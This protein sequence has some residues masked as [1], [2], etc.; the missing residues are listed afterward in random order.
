MGLQSVPPW[1][2]RW[3]TQLLEGL[4]K[5]PQGMERSGTPCGDETTGPSQYDVIAKTHRWEVPYAAVYFVGTG[6]DRPESERPLPSG[7][8]LEEVGMDPAAVV[9]PKAAQSGPL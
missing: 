8:C 7:P 4:N 9:R 6:Y 3:H 1:E 5:S 2:S